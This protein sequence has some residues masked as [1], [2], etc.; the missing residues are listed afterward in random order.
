MGFSEANQVY[1]YTR[2]YQLSRFLR[3][4]FNPL[5][6]THYASLHADEKTDVP[7][8]TW[9]EIAQA[10][11]AAGNFE[12]NPTIQNGDGDKAWNF[13]A[14]GRAG[15]ASAVGGFRDPLMAEA[16]ARLVHGSIAMQSSSNSFSAYPKW[17]IVPVFPDGTTLPLDNHRVYSGRATGSAEHDLMAGSGQGDTLLGE[18]GND[19]VAGFDGDDLIAGG[20]GINYLAGGRGNDRIVIEGGQTYAAGGPGADVFFLGRKATGGAAPL[21]VAEIFDFRPGIDRLSLPQQLGD[22]RAILRGARAQGSGTL[23]PLG[24]RASVLLRGV[25][26]NQLRADSLAMQ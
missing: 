8:R 10:N 25:R 13:A 9:R 19:I 21:G 24:P 16:Y 5:W 4:D 14:Q 22:P 23:I 11:L 26:P 15:Y 6:S 20:P 2:K 12:R 18:G 17:G 1:N 7:F 3:P